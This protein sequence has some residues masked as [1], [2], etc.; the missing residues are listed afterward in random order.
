[1]CVSCWS[2]CRS[3]PSKFQDSW[4]LSDGFVAAEAKVILPH[5]ARS[6]WDSVP[7]CNTGIFWVK[8]CIHVLVLFITRPDLMDNYLA[9]LLS[10]FIN[11]GLLEV[12]NHMVTWCM[13]ACFFTFNGRGLW[14]FTDNG[15]GYSGSGGSGDQQ[16]YT[17]IS[18]SHYT[19]RRTSA[20]GITLH[21]I[22]K[23]YLLHFINIYYGA[24]NLND[25][26]FLIWQLSVFL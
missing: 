5:R 21:Q 3:D 10:A 18:E 7:C 16:W 11:S 8:L 6:R 26:I 9:L 1:M 17:D 13:L 12:C 4:R 25:V 19:A 22:C 15:F 24:M 23:H 20:H 14:C 2:L